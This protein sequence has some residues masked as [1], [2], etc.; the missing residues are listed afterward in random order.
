PKTRR[1]FRSK[2]DHLSR[3]QGVEPEDPAPRREWHRGTYV[4]RG[5]SCAPIAGLLAGFV[6]EAREKIASAIGSHQD[7]VDRLVLPGTKFENE[8]ADKD[9]LPQLGIKTRP[10]DVTF[11]GRQVLVPVASIVVGMN[12][13]EVPRELVNH[14]ADFPGEIG[15]PRVEA[16]AHLAGS[17]FAE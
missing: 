10:V 14:A 6:A 16:G 17:D 3:Q 11:T 5:A 13:L 2:N 1:A 8:G 15:M 7:V 4:L 12:Q 9:G